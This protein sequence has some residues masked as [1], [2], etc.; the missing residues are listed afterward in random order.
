MML[1][2]PQGPPPRT[3]ERATRPRRA[4]RAASKRSGETVTQPTSPSIASTRRL[5]N[6]ELIAGIVRDPQFGAMV[7]L[8]VGGI[9]AEAVAEVSPMTICAGFGMQRYTNSGQTMRAILALLALTGNLGET[10]AGWQFANLQSDLFS[11]GVVAYEMLTGERPFA[12]SH[13]AE[14]VEVHAPGETILIAGR[15]FIHAAFA[16]H[17]RG[18]SL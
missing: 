5:S 4:P 17:C 10:G 2:G 6:R 15:R 12:G 14:V 18:S 13:Y 11:L 16:Y 7:M 8:G 1:G 9:L 3:I